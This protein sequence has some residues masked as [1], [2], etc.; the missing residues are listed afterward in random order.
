MKHV[1]HK[2]SIIVQESFLIAILGLATGRSAAVPPT[3]LPMLDHFR[4]YPIVVGAVG[5]PGNLTVRLSDQF[6]EALEDVMVGFNLRF[7][8]PA[9]KTHDGPGQGMGQTTDII[10]VNAHLVFYQIQE[11]RDDR[12]PNPRFAR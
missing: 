5:P 7:C 11:I 1:S 2:A 9:K 3:P 6:N 12:E 8:N 10:D 4:C